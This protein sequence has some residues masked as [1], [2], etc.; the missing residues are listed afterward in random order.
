[1]NRLLEL[2]RW[3]PTDKVLRVSAAMGLVALALMCLGV[4]DPRPLQ[5]VI[6]MSVSHL[7][8]GIAFVGYLLSVAADLAQARSRLHR[9]VAARPPEPSDAP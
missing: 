3:W 7:F 5:V 1:M 9:A 6:S 2:L 8:G 4:V